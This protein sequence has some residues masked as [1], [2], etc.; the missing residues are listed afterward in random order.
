MFFPDQKEEIGREEQR[1]R[2]PGDL[3]NYYQDEGKVW[4]CRDCQGEIMAITVAHP[5]WFRELS[6]AGSGECRYEQVPYCPNC[7]E[8]PN[9]HGN[10]IYVSLMDSMSSIGL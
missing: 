7:E 4:R 1:K 9:P 8:E 6:C 2:K 5:I 10:P 3:N